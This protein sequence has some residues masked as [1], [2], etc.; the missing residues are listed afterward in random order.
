MSGSRH[1]DDS[2]FSK[3]SD[4]HSLTPS[5]TNLTIQRTAL[6]IIKG[7]SVGDSLGL[8]VEGLT[9]EQILSR[10]GS[11]ITNLQPINDIKYFKGEYPAGTVSDDTELTL[12]SIKAVSRAGLNMDLIAAELISSYDEATRARPSEPHPIG[13]GWSV[14]DAVIRL[15]N[16]AHW[17]ES[18]KSDNPTM[19]FGNGAVIRIAPV[20]IELWRRGEGLPLSE[21]AKGFLRDFTFL[22]H[23]TPTALI[24][25]YA[26]T[27][28]LL[29][30]LSTSLEEFSVER[31]ISIVQEAAISESANDST[32]LSENLHRLHEFSSDRGEQ[33]LRECCGTGL[34]SHL[35]NS[36][37]LTFISFLRNPTSFE[38]LLECVNHGEDADSN[39]SMVG[40]LLGALHKDATMFE[41]FYGRLNAAPIINECLEFYSNH[42][43]STL[44]RSE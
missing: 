9:R 7:I 27:A 43:D 4:D 11:P 8:A 19:G 22:T 14:G 3:A 13:W 32:K 40:A 1:V 33:L 17:S 15:R 34:P 10:F 28:G 29:Y 24:G 39:A 36:L 26:F 6:A 21:S 44:P 25:S 20:A 23:A 30:N 38:A 42:L 12:S 31:F 41:Q 37:P 18:G 2:R 16:G 35:Q 5:V